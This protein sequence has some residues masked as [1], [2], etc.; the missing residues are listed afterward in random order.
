MP[1]F[2]FIMQKEI[3]KRTLIIKATLVMSGS[4]SGCDAGT[5]IL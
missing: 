1:G 4:L 3:N 2:L 5:A